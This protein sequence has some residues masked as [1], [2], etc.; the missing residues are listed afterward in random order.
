MPRSPLKAFSILTIKYPL[1]KSCLI[2][3]PAG[4]GPALRPCLVIITQTSLYQWYGFN[5]RPLPALHLLNITP[6]WVSHRSKPVNLA[7]APLWASLMSKTSS[8]PTLVAFKRHLHCKAKASWMNP[9]RLTC[10]CKAHPICLQA[11]YLSRHSQRCRVASLALNTNLIFSLLVRTHSHNK[12]KRLLR[13]CKG[14]ST[15]WTIH[16]LSS[17]NTR[18]HK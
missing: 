15:K 14:I 12:E 13:Q 5:K 17:F 8:H 1:L 3:S 9:S 18:Q 2:N 4:Q 7:K 6:Q 11:I 16:P 10:L